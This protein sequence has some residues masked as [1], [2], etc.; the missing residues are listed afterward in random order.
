MKTLKLVSC[1]LFVS[2]VMAIAITGNAHAD[3]ERQQQLNQIRRNA[4]EQQQLLNQ[5]QMLNIMRQN[6]MQQWPKANT[7]IY[8][9]LDNDPPPVPV[10]PLFVPI[11][12]PYGG[13]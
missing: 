7:N 4:Y 12:A 6:Q 5:Q 8:R 11:Y 1:Y 3:Y 9:M 2:L 10:T 13:Q